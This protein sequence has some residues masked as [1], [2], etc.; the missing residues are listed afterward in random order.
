M[1]T[2][3]TYHKNL[4]TTFFDTFELARNSSSMRDIHKVRVSIK[5]IKS[6]ND[7]VLQ[8]KNRK[9][10]NTGY[11]KVLKNVFQSAGRI[12]EQQIHLKLL[13]KTDKKVFEIYFKHI[14]KEYK[15]N[16][17]LLGNSL[18]LVSVDQLKVENK[19]IEKKLKKLGKEHINE[20]VSSYVYNK[21]MLIGILKKYAHIDEVL[22]DIR[23]EFRT[24][25][26]ALI[27]C[28]ELGIDSAYSALLEELNP[29]ID[30]IGTW[31]D[32][33]VLNASLAELKANTKKKKDLKHI[34]KH[35]KNSLQKEQ[36]IKSK[37]INKEIGLLI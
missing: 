19:P 24:I 11:N 36:K 25:R 20:H 1:S 34:E 3:S 30:T 22:H 9:K 12:R 29:L 15:N 14:H 4:F 28:K 6:L 31:H 17:L 21:L 35:L 27:L 7:L 32:Y 5:K 37:I 18:R 2:L 23:T 33:N 8:Y 13:Q 16:L 10:Y 26:D